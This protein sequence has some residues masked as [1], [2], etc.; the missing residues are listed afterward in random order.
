M[1]MSIHHL[2]TNGII[3]CMLCL[4]YTLFYYSLFLPDSSLT[5][6]PLNYFKK[7]KHVNITIYMCILQSEES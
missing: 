1:H 6:P 2:S 7:V 4:G 5:V 3:S